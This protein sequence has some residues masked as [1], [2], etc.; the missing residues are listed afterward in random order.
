VVEYVWVLDFGSIESGASRIWFAITHEGHHVTDK[1]EN[2]GNC[3]FGADE[4]RRFGFKCRRHAPTSVMTEY[5]M[6]T[7]WPNVQT[8]DFC[9]DF[10]LKDAE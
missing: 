3:A 1:V 2:C 8:R 5:G 7:F 10:E 6:R 4:N 9:G